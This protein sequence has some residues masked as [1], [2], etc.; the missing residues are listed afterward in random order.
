[1]GTTL[2]L[3]IGSALRRYRYGVESEAVL[4]IRCSFRG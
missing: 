4:G 3:M 1:M 2:A